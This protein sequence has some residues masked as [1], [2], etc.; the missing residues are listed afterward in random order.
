MGGKKRRRQEKEV[1]YRAWAEAGLWIFQAAR[2]RWSEGNCWG[3]GGC[4]EVLPVALLVC[5]I[6][7]H[8]TTGGEGPM[9]YGAQVGSPNEKVK[10]LGTSS[11]SS[12]YRSL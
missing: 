5:Q 12:S 6:L 7:Y 4:V 2:G 3:G 8:A 11:G 10:Y 1:G 9:E